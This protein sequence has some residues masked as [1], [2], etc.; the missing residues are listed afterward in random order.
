MIVPRAYTS[1]EI[2]SVMLDTQYR[3]HPAI[4]A[5]PNKAFYES[6][7]KDGT[8][9]DNG[10]VKAGLEPPQSD[11]TRNEVTGLCRTVTFLH[12]TGQEIA[13]AKSIVNEGEAKIVYDVVGDLLLRNPVSR[14]LV[15][16]GEGLITRRVRSQELKGDDI[17][18]IAPYAGQISCIVNELRH[19]SKRQEQ[20][21]G[22][23]GQNRS[24]E[25]EDVE[26]H[27]VDGFEGREKK[28]IVFSTTRSNDA[29]SIGFLADWRRMNVGLTRA[30][31]VSQSRAL[32]S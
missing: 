14:L 22:V 1:L 31:A 16:G 9:D 10:S 21:W 26:V 2:P 6:K 17:G 24:Q 11:L 5:F 7:L 15:H 20:S 13:R 3:M 29:N 28:V 27:T 30:K 8:R 18:V 25:V 4:S 19:D 12:H 23:L 32:K